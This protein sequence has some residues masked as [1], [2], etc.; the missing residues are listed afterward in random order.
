LVAATPSVVPAAIAAMA[1]VITARCSC[2]RCTARYLS[3]RRGR[4]WECTD[5]RG[6]LRRPY[7]SGD[8]V[9]TLRPSL[10]AITT[11]SRG[12]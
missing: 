8:G 6:S 11:A 2:L 1:N 4:R 10:S 12:P 3:G 7:V 9:R 5:T